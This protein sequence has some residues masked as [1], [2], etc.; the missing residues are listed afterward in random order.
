MSTDSESG[1]MSDD[2]RYELCVNTD[3]E[4]PRLDF[5]STTFRQMINAMCMDAKR[6]EYR[7]SELEQRITILELKLNRLG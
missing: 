4:V 7:T 5:R 1:T 3:L 6:N 2:V